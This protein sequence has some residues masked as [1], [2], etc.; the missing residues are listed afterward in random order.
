MKLFKLLFSII[1]IAAM[2]LSISV[3]FNLPFVPVAALLIGLSSIPT[4]AGVIKVVVSNPLIGKSKQSMGN[5]TFSTWKG[6][7]VLKEKPQSVANPNS[8]TQ[9]MRRS[10]FT[11]MVLA[12]RNM[13]AVIRAGF[14]K[15][16]VKK[17]EFNAFMSYNLQ[18]AF[19]YLT[20]PDALLAGTDVLISKGTISSTPLSTMAADRSSNTIVVT[21]P[22]TTLQPGQSV[23]DI[24]LV[25]AYNEDQNDFYGEVTSAARADGTATITLPAA[26]ITG[27]N[28]VIYLGFYN[29]L[30]GESSDS[31]S[32][33]AIIVS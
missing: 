3:L 17:S 22:T 11:Q 18:N 10:A 7:N 29:P 1:L 21:Y 26:W 2:T 23:T 9:Q 30:S 13:P 20:P 14:K 19:D 25:A 4:V 28:V 32:D 6:I 5:A 16:A 12:F 15:L 8:D 31:V 27:D 33:D 24:A